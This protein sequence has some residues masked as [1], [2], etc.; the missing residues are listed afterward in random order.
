MFTQ[1]ISNVPSSPKQTDVRTING[2]HSALEYASDWISIGK[3]DLGED[4]TFD[5]L[6]KIK[7]LGIIV[8]LN[9]D[10]L[11]DYE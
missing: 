8:N 5:Q 4:G 9:G 7:C 6:W 1:E 10:K 2:D 11:I 3:H